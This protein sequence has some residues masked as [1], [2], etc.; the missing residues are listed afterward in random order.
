MIHYPHETPPAKGTAREIADGILWIRLS[1]PLGLDHVNVYALREPNGWTVIDTGLDTKLNR[2]EW[3]AIITDDLRGDPIL[4][5]V[6]THHHPD[7]VGLAGWFMAQG[8]EL[9]MTRTAW[10]T[11]RMLT[12]DEEPTPSP[13]A[14]SFWRGAGM[15]E[16]LLSKRLDNRPFNFCDTVYPLPLGFTR[17][18]E[19]AVHRLGGRDWVVHLG[20]GHA[21]DHATLWCQDAPLVLAG[22]QLLPSIS[23]N[24][25]V[26]PTEP[27]ADPVAEWLESCARFETMAREDHLVL[28][29]HKLPYYGLPA[30]L[31]QLSDNHHGAL[32]R[33]REHLR[34]EPR[35]AVDCFAPLFKRQI[36]EA[37]YGLAMVEAVAHLNHL[38][39]LG[40]VAREMDAR[41]AW[42]W[43]L[44]S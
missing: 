26:Y 43:Q 24:L 13:E 31:A 28:P 12:L 44:R 39:H 35:T 9:W 27:M 23:P 25:G 17:L 4:R 15:D 37:T 14:V 5:V 10:L 42:V 3:A 2:R 22:D 16:A 32:A 11:A 29:G 36:D 40:E 34:A 8:A 21:P 41:G 30:R 6:V 33:L 19:G 20:Q 18:E 1:M 7:H 38:Y